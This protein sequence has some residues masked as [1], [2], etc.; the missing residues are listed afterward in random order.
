MNP[1]SSNAPGPV[2]VGVD[3]SPNS[4]KALRLARREAN[5]RGV[6]LRAVR[7]WRVPVSYGLEG[8]AYPIDSQRLEE[9]ARAVLDDAIAQAFPD[10][11]EQATVAREVLLGATS[12]LLID[13][14]K[15]ADLL[16]VGARG[17]GGFVGLM[18][19]SVSSQVVKHA[20]CP[21]LVVPPDYE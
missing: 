8:V 3:G 17:H 20:H 7:S 10:Q 4:V 16:V 14:S 5:W 12:E 2:V 15:T 19:G 11:A 6:P 1:S 9:G 21:V 13:A 18:L